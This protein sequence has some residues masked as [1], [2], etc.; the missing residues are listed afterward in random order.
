VAVDITGT[1][2][3]KEAA[4]IVLADDTFASITAR[5]EGGPNRLQQYRKGDS[6]TCCR[7]T[8]HTGAGDLGRG[9]NWLYRGDHRTTDPEVNIVTSVALG[10]VHLI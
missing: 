7:P 3:T 10:L 1:Q 8:S 6:R 4:E 9:F 2:V 5:R